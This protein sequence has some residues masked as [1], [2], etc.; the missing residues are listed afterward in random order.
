MASVATSAKGD[1]GASTRTVTFLFVDQVA[2]TAQLA[3]LGDEHGRTVRERLMDALRDA[4]DQCSGQE[5][6]FTGD[7]LFAAFDSARAG[8]DAAVLMQ[9]LVTS[10]NRRSTPAEQTAI[11]VGVHVGEALDAADGYFGQAVVIAKR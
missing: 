5:V 2:S 9:Q 6:S 3:A 7:G 1:A 8:V 4:N 11:R 10:L